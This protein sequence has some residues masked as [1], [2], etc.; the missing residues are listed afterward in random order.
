MSNSL[1]P[2]VLAL[3]VGAKQLTENIGKSCELVQ[4]VQPGERFRTPDGM[5][6]CGGMMLRT[7]GYGLCLPG[8]LV[9]LKGDGGDDESF[10]RELWR[11]AL[12]EQRA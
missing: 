3:I 6:A 4:L 9:P 8:Y 10:A 5:R 2:G 1:K 7:K 11:E 12:Q